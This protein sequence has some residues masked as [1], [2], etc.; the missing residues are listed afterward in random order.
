LGKWLNQFHLKHYFLDR[1][2]TV[3]YAPLNI[4]TINMHGFAVL[5][6]KTCNHLKIFIHSQ[7]KSFLSKCVN[8]KTVYEQILT[9]F[10]SVKVWTNTFIHSLFH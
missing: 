9:I 10:G 2:N 7:I 1:K 4:T 3:K 6:D 8:F 5:K